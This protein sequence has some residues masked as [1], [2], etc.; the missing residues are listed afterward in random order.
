MAPPLGKGLY[1]QSDSFRARGSPLLTGVADS[2]EVEV[3]AV[4][5]ALVALTRSRLHTLVWNGAVTRVPR[6]HL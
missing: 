2:G 4:A 1:P 6:F 3:V 5:C